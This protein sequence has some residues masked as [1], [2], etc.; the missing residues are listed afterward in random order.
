[1]ESLNGQRYF[2]YQGTFVE[3]FGS[4]AFGGSGYTNTPIG[5]VT[6]VDEPFLYGLE[7]SQLYFGLWAGG[8][9]FAICAWVSRNTPF[10]QGNRRSLCAS[11][12]V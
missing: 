7:N 6:H 8:N 5:A 4:D 10:F 1:M 12:V 2:P 9:N 3:W 11:I